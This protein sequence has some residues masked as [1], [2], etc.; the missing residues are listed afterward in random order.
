MTISVFD[1]WLKG[2]QHAWMT[3]D[4]SASCALFCEDAQ[5]FITPFDSPLCGQ[6]EL[7]IYWRGVVKSQR[8][9]KFEFSVLSFNQPIGIA[10]WSVSFTRVKSR[11]RREL[12]G[13]LM[14]EF[15]EAG[16]CRIF[17][18]WW[19]SRRIVNDGMALE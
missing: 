4:A 11:K 5:Y 12:D 14:A 17:R 2:Y 9:V 15:D 18:E 19:H 1:D 10:H 8:N 7:G 16:Q 3:L 13:I 6:S